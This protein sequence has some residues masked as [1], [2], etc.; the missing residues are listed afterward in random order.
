[1]TKDIIGTIGSEGRIYIS[2]PL[3]KA[4][5]F[6]AAVLFQALLL[7]QAYYEKQGMLDPE[8]YFYSTIEDM[9][10]S[11]SLS[12]HQQNKAVKTLVQE[13]LIDFYT[14]GVHYR[15]HFRIPDNAKELLMDIFDEYDENLQSTLQ[16][17]DKVPCE[18]LTEYPVSNSQ[19]TLQENDKPIYINHNKINNNN[20][21]LSI[22]HIGKNV[23]DNNDGIDRIDNTQREMYFKIIRSNISYDC[24][25]NED[26]ERADQLIELMLDVICSDKGTIRVNGENVPKETVKNRFLDLKY[27]HIEYVLFALERNTS[28]VKNIRSYLI[29]ALYNSPTTRS[30]YYTAEVNHDLYGT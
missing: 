18:K 26:R 28:K 12:R 27:E 5:G 8:G 29:T 3:T 16:E 1:M 2:R 20:K 22:N 4:L 19:G 17:I 23:S 21:N 15:R 30:H 14:G 6:N 25:P 9:E 13:G 11:T 10:S 24:I 7:K